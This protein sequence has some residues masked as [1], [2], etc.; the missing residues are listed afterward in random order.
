MF[1]SWRSYVKNNNI[2]EWENTD[3]NNVVCHDYR[4]VFKKLRRNAIF[5][6]INYGCYM[7]TKLS[8]FKASEA[9]GHKNKSEKFHSYKF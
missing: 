3:N 4:R 9:V 5:L 8:V 2:T 1:R 6:E 7:T